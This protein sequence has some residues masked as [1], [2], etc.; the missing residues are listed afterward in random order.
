MLHKYGADY[1]VIFVGDAT[2]SPYEIA[3]PGG[4]VE[5]WNAE[6]GAVW[7]QRIKSVYRHLVWLNPQPE[8]YWHTIPSCL[9]TQEL[10]DERMFPLTVAGLEQAIRALRKQH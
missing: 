10:V 4:A 5:H 9:L 6:A 8:A 7:M 3:Y 1:R 2:M